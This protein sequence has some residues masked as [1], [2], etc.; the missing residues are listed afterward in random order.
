MT[1]SDG[2]SAPAAALQVTATVPLDEDGDY[3][4]GSPTALAVF[5][6]AR[7]ALELLRHYHMA[8]LT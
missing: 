1:L 7:L 8:V 5:R 4:L 3:Q 6:E 2:A